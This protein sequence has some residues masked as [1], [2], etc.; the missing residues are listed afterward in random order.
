[1]KIVVL[2]AGALGSIIGGHLVRAGEDVIFLARGQRAAFLQ[3]H[4]IVVTGLADFTVPVTVTTHPHEV[5]AADVLLVTVKTYDTEAALASLR[6]LRVP[7]VLSVQNGVLKNEQL[8]CIFGRE[9]VLGAVAHA[10]GE[11]L[12]DGAVRFTVNDHLA[13]GELPEGT[14]ER[15]QS[16]VAT[17]ARAGLRAEASPHIQTVEWSKYVLFVGGMALA[18]LTRLTTAKFLSDPDGALLMARLMRELG[19]IATRLGI[20]LEDAGPLPIK[21]LCSGS[22][23]EAVEHVQRFGAVMSARAPAHKVSTLQDLERGRR[24]EVEETLGYA[25]RKGAELDVPLPTVETCYRLLAGINR[26][27]Q[28]GAP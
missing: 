15:A 21:T 23:P 25:V 5:Q 20:P 28:G 24:L 19:H 18:S 17:L 2:G 4:G 27:L 26:H 1:M 16:L 14:S 6:H 3:Q 13:L 12:P 8:A 11:V 22:L 7:S 9:S 10:A